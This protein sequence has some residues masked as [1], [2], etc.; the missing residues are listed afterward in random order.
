MSGELNNSVKWR[1]HLARGIDFLK[2]LAYAIN[3]S[4][5]TVAAQRRIF[6]GLP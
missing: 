6:T 3:I 5:L 2:F 4:A 1:C